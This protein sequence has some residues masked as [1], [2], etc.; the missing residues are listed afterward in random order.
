MHAIFGTE[1]TFNTKIMCHPL[2]VINNI[3]FLYMIFVGVVIKSVT[4]VAY[5][6]HV[7][8]K[9]VHYYYEFRLLPNILNCSEKKINV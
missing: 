8:I 1:A 5:K 2:I 7:I 9:H 6:N 3:I 4:A